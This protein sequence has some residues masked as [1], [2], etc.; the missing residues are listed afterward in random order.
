M[1]LCWFLPIVTTFF[2]SEPCNTATETC[3][4]QESSSETKAPQRGIR[5]TT[6]DQQEKTFSEKSTVLEKNNE[7]FERSGDEEGLPIQNAVSSSSN[8]SDLTTDGD[9]DYSNS[10]QTENKPGEQ[11]RKWEAQP[12]NWMF[13]LY[14]TTAKVYFCGTVV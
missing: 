2:S 5:D 7:G 9:A 1:S 14:N 10:M 11:D 12:G 13:T 4:K 3:E 8:T 6:V